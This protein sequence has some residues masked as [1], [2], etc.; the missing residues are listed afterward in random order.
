MPPI[1]PEGGGEPPPLDGAGCE[2]PEDVASGCIRNS[3]NN[4]DTSI[5]A[6]VVGVDHGRLKFL[7]TR[8]FSAAMPRGFLSRQALCVNCQH[9]NRNTCG[10][11]DGRGGFFATGGRQGM[12]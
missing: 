5:L 4:T 3:L 1:P 8:E 11:Q 6:R 7:E 10:G 2:V 9:P 12:L